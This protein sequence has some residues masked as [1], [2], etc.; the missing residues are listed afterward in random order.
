MAGQNNDKKL[1]RIQ[2]K[3][4]TSINWSNE[5]IVLLKGELGLESDTNLIKMGNGVDSW[6]DLPYMLEAELE[7]IAEYVNTEIA[8]AIQNAANRTL[9]NLTNTSTARSNLGVPP[10]S[11]AASGTTYGVGTTSNYGHVRTAGQTGN[12]NYVKTKTG[13][14]WT[15]NINS[16]SYWYSSEFSINFDLS[17][18]GIPLT[19]ED[20]ID[21]SLYSSMQYFEAVLKVE[22]SYPNSRLDGTNWT[23]CKQTLIIPLHELT[24]ERYLDIN[25]AFTEWKK[26]GT[27]N[28][29][30]HTFELDVPADA[31]FVASGDYFE[32]TFNIPQEDNKSQILETDEVIVDIVASSNPTIAEYQGQVYTDI[33]QIQYFDDQVVITAKKLPDLDLRLKFLVMRTES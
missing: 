22:G 9:S 5:N 6:N 26:T 14:S 27:G 19:L 12:G 29:S 10:T 16:N 17:C 21:T 11:H 8:A 24:Y 20:D 2:H 18:V 33:N 32:A 4:D 13:V 23:G 31:G 28:L 7:E 30:I 15:D 25:N 1:V 3:T